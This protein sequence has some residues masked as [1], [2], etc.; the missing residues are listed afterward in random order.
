[1]VR[2]IISVHVGQCGNQIGRAFWK[3][4]LAEHA[5]HN[6]SSLFEPCMST[7]F[8]NVDDRTGL[9][10]P[11][12]DGR[13]SI[14]GL[15]ARAVLVDMEDGP[16]SET[17]RGDLGDLFDQRHIVTDVHGSGNN[18]AHGNAVYGPKYKDDLL[19]VGFGDLFI[20]IQ[21]SLYI[22]WVLIRAPSSPVLVVRRLFE[23]G[24]SCAT[25]SSPFS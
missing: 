1:M 13:E 16:I 25:A 22:Y 15:K 6:Q 24:L 20:A 11:I 10:L 8:R 18:W 23:E 7:F 17:I 5:N 14:Y 3:Q 4:V 21:P 2:E 19:E 9:D 12:G